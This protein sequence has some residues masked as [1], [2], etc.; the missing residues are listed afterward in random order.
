MFKACIMKQSFQQ[1]KQMKKLNIAPLNS[2]SLTSF[3]EVSETCS[4]SICSISSSIQCF[5]HAVMPCAEQVPES[6]TTRGFSNFIHAEFSISQSVYR[7]CIECGTEYQLQNDGVV[8]TTEIVIQN[9]ILSVRIPQQLAQCELVCFSCDLH[10]LSSEF[11]FVAFGQNVSGL[12][13]NYFKN[14]MINESQI[15]FRLSGVNVGG[16]LLQSQLSPIQISDVN[17]SGYVLASNVSGSLI[18]FVSD[19]IQILVSNSKICSNIYKYAGLNSVNLQL[20]GSLIIS[21]EICRSKTYAY[22]HICTHMYTYI[23]NT[24]ICLCSAYLENGELIDNKF[25]CK[26]S[27]EFNGE[28]C[29]CP[30]GQVLNGSLCISVL[31]LVNEVIQRQ[32]MLNQSI[33]SLNVNGLETKVKEL[34]YQQQQISVEIEEFKDVH[35]EIQNSIISNSSSI[36][37]YIVLNTTNILQNLERNTTILDKDITMLLYQTYIEQRLYLTLQI[38]LTL[39]FKLQIVDTVIIQNAVLLRFS[40][41]NQFF[42]FNLCMLIFLYFYQYNHLFNIQNINQT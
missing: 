26:N 27:F 30:D 19:V 18:A 39:K 40:F 1:Q 35:K 16:L 12:V 8:V 20:V 29:H 10:V 37:N 9:S 33:Q 15:Q 23:W 28:Q 34:E 13:L 41:L 14:I 22:V 21:S 3:Y 42:I 24:Y 38:V 7:N 11:A 17:I 2:Q 32:L 31:N 25:V 36:Q 4:C 5:F 6:V